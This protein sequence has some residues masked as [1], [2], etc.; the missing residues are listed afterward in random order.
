[1]RQKSIWSQPVDLKRCRQVYLRGYVQSCSGGFAELVAGKHLAE[2]IRDCI[3]VLNAFVVEFIA[4]LDDVV[5]SAADDSL[6][7]VFLYIPFDQV[8][9]SSGRRGVCGGP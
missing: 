2:E 7:L 1:M 5:L 9:G 6:F 3:V 8:V 4:G